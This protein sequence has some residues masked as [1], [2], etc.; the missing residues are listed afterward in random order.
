[1]TSRP[2]LARWSLVAAVVLVLVLI[3]VLVVARPYLVHNQATSW[4]MDR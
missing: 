1:M 2:R 4:G 3:P